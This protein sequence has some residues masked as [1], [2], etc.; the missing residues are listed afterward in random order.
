L[1]AQTERVLYPETGHSFRFEPNDRFAPIAAI[2][3]RRRNFPK[4]AVR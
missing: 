1:P 2:H 3:L 4:V